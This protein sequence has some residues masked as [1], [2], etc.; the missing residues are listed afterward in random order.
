MRINLDLDL[1]ATVKYDPLGPLKM[2]GLVHSR[3]CKCLLLL[4]WNVSLLCLLHQHCQE[5]C[6]GMAT[7]AAYCS[8][9]CLLLNK[10]SVTFGWASTSGALAMLPGQKTSC[11]PAFP[12]QCCRQQDDVPVDSWTVCA[13]SSTATT[14]TRPW[15]HPL[16]GQWSCQ[17]MNSAAHS[18]PLAC[19]VVYCCVVG[20]LQRHS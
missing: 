15:H 19:I 14:T 5:L 4:C 9:H 16:A 2:D 1:L 7:A 8:G 18:N 11:R 20:A 12:S 10:L 3:L 13:L 6:S 17:C